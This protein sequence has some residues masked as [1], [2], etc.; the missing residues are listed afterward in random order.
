VRTTLFDPFVSEGKENGTGLGLTVVHKIVQDHGGE[1]VVER[2]SE[3]GT[4]FR[5]VLPRPAP[6]AAANEQGSGEDSVPAAQAGV[7]STKPS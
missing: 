4:T 2:T 3:E 7:N 1:V 5:L 6:T